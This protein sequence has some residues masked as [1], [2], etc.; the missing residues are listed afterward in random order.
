MLSIVELFSFTNIYIYITSYIYICFLHHIYIYILKMT[1]KNPP[2]LRGKKTRVQWQPGGIPR[3]CGSDL[4]APTK[5]GM[6]REL[7]FPWKLFVIN[8]YI[9]IYMI[10]Y[11][12]TYI[13]IYIK[14]LIYIY[15]YVYDIYIYIHGL[16]D[17][18]HVYIY[19][20]FNDL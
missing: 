9:N 16:F 19:N 20:Y 4:S 7:G 5:L 14:Y 3:S 12:Y 8:A 1:A 15:M 2:F 13:N 18:Y 11:M 17:V 10:I 6:N